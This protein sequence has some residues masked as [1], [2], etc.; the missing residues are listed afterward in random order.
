MRVGKTMKKK[1]IGYLHLCPFYMNSYGTKIGKK[2]MDF[3]KPMKKKIIGY[4]NSLQ[5]LALHLLL[6]PSI[7]VLLPGLKK[8]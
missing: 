1:N 8:K 3:K 4:L 2:M 5:F 6:L 7:L